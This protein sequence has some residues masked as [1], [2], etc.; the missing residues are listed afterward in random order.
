MRVFQCSHPFR[1]LWWIEFET[2]GIEIIGIIG[3]IEISAIFR[4]GLFR[5]HILFG[6]FPPRGIPIV[7]QTSNPGHGNNSHNF[8][9]FNNS[10]NSHIQICRWG[11]FRPLVLSRFCDESNSGQGGGRLILFELLQV[12]TLLKFSEGGF[13][14]HSSSKECFLPREIRFRTQA[15]GKF[16]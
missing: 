2:S 8:N 11:F 14:D 5:P 7:L 10:N 16:Q 13:S 3:I 9:S 1:I 4:S 6:I 15:P 12:L